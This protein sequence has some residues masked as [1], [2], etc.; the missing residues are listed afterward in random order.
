MLTIAIAINKILGILSFA[1]LAQCLMTWVPGGTQNKV[2]EILTTITDPIQYPIRNVMYKYINGPID[3]TPV[4]S[5]LLINLA[6]RFIFV[7]LL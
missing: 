5:I 6:R 7:I 1:I 4:I 3:F 2:Y